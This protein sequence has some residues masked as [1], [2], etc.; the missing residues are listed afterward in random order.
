MTPPPSFLHSAVNSSLLGPSSP[1][2]PCSPTQHLS[3][4]NPDHVA[5]LRQWSI[6][7]LCTLNA[8]IT[9]PAETQKLSRLK[10]WLDLKG[11]EQWTRFSTFLLQ[12]NTSAFAHTRTHARTRA[13]TN[14][15]HKS[16]QRLQATSQNF[17]RALYNLYMFLMQRFE[18][19]GMWHSVLGWVVS[20]STF[21]PRV[22]TSQDLENESDTTLR[23]VGKHS[24]NHTAYNIPEDLNP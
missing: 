19:S 11:I 18:S 23:N 20:M 12:I 24:P 8:F 9:K 5:F 10:Y 3:H 15:I 13:H 22:I 4:T 21:S 16:F 2:A 17:P 7:R 14:D 6:R 1:R